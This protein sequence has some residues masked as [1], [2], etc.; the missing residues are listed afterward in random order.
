MEATAALWQANVDGEC[1]RLTDLF[2]LRP[3]QEQN[4]PESLARHRVP[5]FDLHLHRGDNRLHKQI[6]I[7]KLSHFAEFFRT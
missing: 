4:I 6:T 7:L 3:S 5:V 2:S 1:F